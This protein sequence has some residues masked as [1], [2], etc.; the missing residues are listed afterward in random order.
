MRRMKRRV[1]ERQMLDRLIDAV[2]SGESRVLVLRGEAG[3]GKSALVDYLA[4]HASGCRVLRAAGVESEMELAFAGL[5]QLFT[6]IWRFVPR[7]PDPQQHAL[8]VAFGLAAGRPPDRFLLGVA[9]LSLLSEAARERP[10]ACLIDDVQWLD[11]ASRETLLFAAR[12]LVA[13]SVAMIF[14]IRDSPRATELG[15]LPEMVVAGLAEGDA[16]ELLASVLPGAMDQQVL[17]RILAEAHGNPLALLELP[18]VETPG[19]LVG[20]YRYDPSAVPSRIEESYRHQVAQ[21]PR[22]TRRLLV[23]AAAES[24]GDPVLVW[25]AARAMGIST[26]HGVDAPATSLVEFG[27]QVRFRHPLVRSAILTAAAARERMRAH[28]SLAEATDPVTDPDRRAWHMA[29]ATSG[30]DEDVALELEHSADR[31]YARGG[32]PAA[33]AFLHRATDLTPDLGRRAERALAAAQAAHHAGSP[34]RSLDLLALA[35]A[36]PLDD[37]HRAPVDLPRR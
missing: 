2:R 34:E 26:E 12:R 10:V 31:A 24:T 11:Q 20:G 28:R 1:A 7:L 25:R 29:Q 35:E 30:T 6:P 14:A 13:E 9:A 36:G 32:W 18:R 33:A 3:I 5:H 22:D 37:F 17:D 21:M 27:T 4:D 8:G 15:G 23:I 19:F 16:R